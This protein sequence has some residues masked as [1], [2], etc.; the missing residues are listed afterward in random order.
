MKK[1]FADPV[2]EFIEIDAVDIICASCKYDIGCLGDGD[3]PGAGP[4]CNGEC[5]NNSGCFG[6]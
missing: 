6:D 2:S 1:L 5:P 4:G 3:E